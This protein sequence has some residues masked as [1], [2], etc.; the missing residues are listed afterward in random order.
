MSNNQKMNNQEDLVGDEPPPNE[1]D[2]NDEERDD[3]KS[4]DDLGGVS[5]SKDDRGSSWTD[6]DSFER[7]TEGWEDDYRVWRGQQVRLTS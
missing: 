2:C 6:E 3:L 1:G 7:L 4:K 5:M